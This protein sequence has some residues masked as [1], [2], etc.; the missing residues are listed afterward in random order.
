MTPIHSPGPLLPGLQAVVTGGCGGIGGAVSAAFAAH[1]ARVLAVDVDVPGDVPDGVDTL[2]LDVTEP[3]AA[4]RI[5]G[6]CE[7]DVVVHNVGH[8]LRA[9]RRFVEEGPDDWARMFRVNVDHALE[10]TAALLPGMLARGRGGSVISMTTVEAHRAIP[11]HAVYSG[12]KAALMA[13]SRSMALEHGPDGIRFNTIAPDLVE[14]PQVPYRERVAEEDW[15]RWRLWAPLARPGT[16]DDVAGPALFLA[17]PLSAY[18]TGTTLHVDGGSHAAGGWFPR[19]D[20]SGWTN[21]PYAP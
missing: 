20:G 8:F 6:Q 18:V 16:P 7:P 21:R 1:G 10:L 5:A 13:W 3:G 14:T 15:W 4:A 2:V 12:A 17:S 19:E 11:G 9:P